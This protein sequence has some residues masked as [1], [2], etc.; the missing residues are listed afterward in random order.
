MAANDAANTANRSEALFE[1]LRL[2]ILSGV[3]EP[4][5]RLRFAELCRSYASSAGTIREALQRLTDAGLV[6]SQGRLG[7]R[8]AP[9]SPQDLQELIDARLEV[10]VAVFRRSLT[11]G[12]VTWETGMI[13]AHH[14][15]DRLERNDADW[16]AAHAEFHLALLRGCANRRLL[17]FA[18]AL[19]DSAEVYRRWSL[20]VPGAAE[21]DS[22]EE[23]HSI[24]QAALA[25]DVDRAVELLA[26]HIRRSKYP[27]V[28]SES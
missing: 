6:E 21:R 17:R 3:R 11:E 7:F 1:R 24:L 27:T 19:R 16:P 5:T 2:D 9:L 10:E 14:L 13:V 8:V 28:A 4:G 23:H 12:D 20:P 15:L 22:R 25:R 26:E 18:G